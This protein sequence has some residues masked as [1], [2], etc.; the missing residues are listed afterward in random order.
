[1]RRIAGFGS[2]LFVLATAAA[3]LGQYGPT[4][5]TPVPANQRPDSYSGGVV[6]TSAA[7][8]R[9]PAAVP[10]VFPSYAG[11]SP[12]VLALPDYG[13]ASLPPVGEGGG[14]LPYRSVLPTF[15]QNTSVLMPS[16]MQPPQA[17]PAGTIMPGSSPLETAVA[18]GCG[19]GCCNTCPPPCAPCC[20]W[21]GGVAG[22]FMGRD[23]ANKFWTSA[24]G[25]HPENQVMNTN[26]PGVPFQGGYEVRLGRYF[27]G[28]GY[29]IGGAALGGFGGVGSCNG[30]YAVEGVYW[31]LAPLNGYSSVNASA[32]NDGLVTPIILDAPP[33]PTIGPYN[34]SDYFDGALKHELW[35]RD[36][37]YNIELNFWRLP[38]FTPT[39]RFQVNW[40]AGVRYLR[41]TDD[42]VFGAVSGSQTIPQI[43]GTEGYLDTKMTNNL[44]GF[45]IGGRGNYFLTRTVSIY[46][47]PVVGLFGN[48]ATSRMHLYNAA[49]DQGFNYSGK[50]NDVAILGQIDLGTQWFLTPRW[51][52]FAAYRVIGLAGVGLADNQIPT[53]LND[54]PAIQDVH[55]NGSLIVSGGVFGTWFAY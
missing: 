42:L 6:P 7:M 52:I 9:N 20:P 32:P 19:D 29:G 4:P 5:G 47:Q 39:Q 34:A 33:V 3:A 24:D 13:S 28:P 48:H 36:Y 37:L 16:Q 46:A 12:G 17:L 21:F 27:G 51:S 53:Y 55:S 43:Y 15:A 30:G 1:M 44:V 10:P 14:V 40:M 41:F 2:L 31:A 25:N 23:R 35:R 50:L 11:T 54:T 26:D 38:L 18:G 49:G 22:L 8:A 45:Q